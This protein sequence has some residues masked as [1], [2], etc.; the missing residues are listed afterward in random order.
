MWLV[1]LNLSPTTP[2]RVV[3]CEHLEPLPSGYRLAG[4]RNVEITQGDETW[5]VAEWTLTE[6]MVIAFA[7]VTRAT[8]AAVVPPVEGS[9]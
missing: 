9:Q 7:R 8:P 4:L 6:A 3:L 1:W 5:A 2:P